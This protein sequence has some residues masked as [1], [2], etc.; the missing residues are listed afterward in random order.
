VSKPPYPYP[1]DEFDVAGHES[2]PRGVHRA[3]RSAWATAAPFILVVLLFSGLAYGLVTYLYSWQGITL[4][5]QEVPD[6][7]QGDTPSSTPST[8]ATTPAT[9]PTTVPPVAPTP[10]FATPVTVYNSTSIRGLAAQ[11][12][13]ALK[14]AGFTK[15]TAE[16]FTGKKP[17]TSTVF[18]ASDDLKVTA[19]AAAA[20][21]GITTVT[22][23]PPDAAN[24]IAV[25]LVS[26]FRP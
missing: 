14:G 19:E 24:G 16:N 15:V 7:L 13:A 22:L 10:L 9:T 18:Y 26:D 2:G 21:L 3:P 12:A 1:E 8:T 6:D 20:S 11:G 5:G 4:P 23:S 17:K 25:V